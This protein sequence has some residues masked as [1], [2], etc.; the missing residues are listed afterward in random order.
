MISIVTLTGIGA[1][2]C[3]RS[4]ALPSD[5]GI[6]GPSFRAPGVTRIP[7]RFPRRMGIPTPV[8]PAQKLVGNPWKPKVDERDWQYIML[9]HT[10][11]STGSV[12]SIHEAHIA[13]KDSKGN[14]WKGIGY[15]FV[16]GNGKGMG[17]GAI[18]PTFRWR[19]QMHGAHA[20]V[21]K[22]NQKGIGIVLVGNFEDSTPS[23]AQ[24]AAVKKL[25]GVLKADYGIGS[26]QII[27]HKDVKA[28]ACPGRMFPLAEISRSI[29]ATM[30]GH[31]EHNSAP[32]QSASAELAPVEFAAF[33][34]DVQP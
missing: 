24:L 2:G 1:A 7:Q 15:H 18:E 27:A 3:Y 25:V 8:V 14:P 23:P 29:D 20:G 6:G 9:H 34:K 28:T 13:R 12:E 19:E 5:A 10:A 32:V 22:Y 33:E 16:I 4:A 11:S 17:D 30:M 21:N 26:E 31:H